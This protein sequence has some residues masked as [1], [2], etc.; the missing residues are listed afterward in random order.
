M[1]YQILRLIALFTFALSTQATAGDFHYQI[2]A[3]SKI[4]SAPNKQLGALQMS[5]LYDEQTTTMLL[6]D[7]DL[8][9]K[10]RQH[11]LNTIGQRTIKDLKR[12]NYFTDIKINGKPVKLAPPENLMVELIDGKYFRLFFILPFSETVDAK[13]GTLS[14]SLL[15]PNGIALPLFDSQERISVDATLQNSCHVN[16]VNFEEYKHGTAAQ[17]V[18]VSCK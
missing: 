10:K 8:S 7:A 5:W 11:S 9:P 4:L 2:D 15:D 12:L 17:R 14:F 13:N 1:K 16:L 6:Q 3:M 18:D